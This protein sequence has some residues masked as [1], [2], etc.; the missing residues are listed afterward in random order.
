MTYKWLDAT[1]TLATNQQTNKYTK[2]ILPENV[3]KYA[4]KLLFAQNK[5]K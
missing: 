3:L 5:I 2:Y 4:Q 1:I